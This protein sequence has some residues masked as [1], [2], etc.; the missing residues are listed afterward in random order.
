MI[1]L[2]HG[3]FCP[4]ARGCVVVGGGVVVVR[5][6]RATDTRALPL[7]DQVHVP[8]VVLKVPLLEYQPLTP[9]L[10]DWR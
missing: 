6:L 3:S 10:G 5:S 9:R 2:R 8:W 7:L 1:G 4:W